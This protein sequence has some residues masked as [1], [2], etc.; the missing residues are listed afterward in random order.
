MYYMKTRHGEAE[1]RKL[2]HEPL[3]LR[4]RSLI[5][6]SANVDTN[7][8]AALVQIV[9]CTMKNTLRFLRY[10]PRR[11][12]VREKPPCAWKQHSN[13]PVVD[14]AVQLL[15]ERN[16]DAILARR[17]C[18]KIHHNIILV[19]NLIHHADAI[20]QRLRLRRHELAALKRA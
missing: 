15:H 16:F 20:A 6:D 19:H 13:K 1:N 7:H 11:W 14:R 5:L 9:G 2:A 17:V 18:V 12:F 10:L 4:M 3:M 8:T